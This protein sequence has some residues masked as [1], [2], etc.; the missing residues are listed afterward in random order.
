MTLSPRTRALLKAQ[1][2]RRAQ[3]ESDAEKQRVRAGQD[4]RR[5][6]RTYG[7]GWDEGELRTEL[8]P[9]APRHRPSD[10]PSKVGMAKAAKAWIGLGLKLARVPKALAESGGVMN[11]E[12]KQKVGKKAKQGGAQGIII[13]ILTSVGVLIAY[14]FGVDIFPD[15][16][17]IETL[18]IAI[19]SLISAITA[20]TAAVRAAMNAIKHRDKAQAGPAQENSNDTSI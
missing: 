6:Q 12:Y 11:P 14:A 7:D 9:P 17:S 3:G 13:G 16:A 20:I 19:C 8:Q 4:T 2:A 18:A 1:R 10:P 5:G 15:D